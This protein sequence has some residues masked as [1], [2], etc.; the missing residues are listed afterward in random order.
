MLSQCLSSCRDLYLEMAWHIFSSSPP[1]FS[2]FTFSFYPVLQCKKKGRWWTGNGRSL[3]WE[4]T[5]NVHFL[6]CT[7]ELVELAAT[8]HD[9]SQEVTVHNSTNHKTCSQ[10][11]QISLAPLL[12]IYS[13]SGLVSVR[14]FLWPKA[15]CW[16]HL[17]IFISSL[18]MWCDEL[19][20]SSN[21]NANKS[22]ILTKCSSA[23]QG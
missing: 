21:R 10:K 13:K 16:L 9:W 7:N 1:L 18:D 22:V 19:S 11:T 12:K 20:V 2:G 14:H 8:G 5:T 3:K 15:C 4:K 6:L 23:L 17:G